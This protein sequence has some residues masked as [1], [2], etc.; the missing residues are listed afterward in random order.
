MQKGIIIGAVILILLVVGLFIFQKA[1]QEEESDINTELEAAL[2]Q[3]M[4][5]Q[6][7]N[8]QESMMEETK[9]SGPPALPE[10]YA[11]ASRAVIK[12]NLGDITVEFYKEDSPKTAENFMAL[13]ASGFYDG[14]RFHRV[15][16]NFM[17]QAGDPLS[18]DD[19][20]RGIW[21]T[22]GPGYTFAD[23]FNDHKIV[24]GSLAMANRGPDTNGSQFFIVTAAAT[25][26]LDGMHTNFGRVV[27]GMDVV[28][29][30]GQTATNSS[31]QPVNDVVIEGIEL[32]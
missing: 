25:P 11:D 28:E 24:K 18:K 13:A 21:G 5:K 17:I 29:A 19:E 22:G 26:W 27:D 4:D 6:V 2:E 12:T 23:E 3:N 30:I 7:N 20:Q 31:D 1:P 15:I 14:T 10:E 9:L 32:K 8:N 16:D